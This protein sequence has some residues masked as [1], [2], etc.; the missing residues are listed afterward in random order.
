MSNIE[1][2]IFELMFPNIQTCCAVV[3]NT[4]YGLIGVHLTKSDSSRFLDIAARIAAKESVDKS[5][6]AVYFIGAL[7]N[8]NKTDLRNAFRTISHNIFIYDTSCLGYVDLNARKSVGLSVEFKHKPSS[9]Y[10]P[11][12]PIST[13]AIRPL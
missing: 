10:G 4:G 5:S 6:S 12:I 1:T 9:A 13:Y 3:V 2:D 11:Y 8:Y 7:S